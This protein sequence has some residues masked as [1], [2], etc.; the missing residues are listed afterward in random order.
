MIEGMFYPGGGDE[1]LNYKTDKWFDGD[2]KQYDDLNPNDFEYVD[3]V[4]IWVGAD[5]GTG[6]W[7]TVWG[8]F[9]DQAFIEDMLAYNY[10]PDGVSELIIS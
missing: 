7:T 9:E 1:Y 10:G 4:I 5:D 8:P 2:S 3:R 6:K